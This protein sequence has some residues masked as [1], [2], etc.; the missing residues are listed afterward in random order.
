MT[1]PFDSFFF[2]KHGLPHRRF[3]SCGFNSCGL[4]LVDFTKANGYVREIWGDG[5]FRTKHVL[6]F[7]PLVE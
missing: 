3:K 7:E 2:F 1:V 4:V 6:L 5:S